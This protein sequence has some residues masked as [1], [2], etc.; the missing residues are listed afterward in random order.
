MENSNPIYNKKK[1]AGKQWAGLIFLILGIVLLIR[2][3][4]GF[5][6]DWITS[7]PMVLI[8][9]G[10]FTGSRHNY[11]NPGSIILICLGV[12][13]LL[14]RII[15]GIDL[16]DFVFPCIIIGLGLYLILGKT[17]FNKHFVNRGRMRN[18]VVWDKRVNVPKEEPV[19]VDG[20]TTEEEPSKDSGDSS[21]SSASSSEQQYQAG[22][23]DGPEDYLDTV[24]IFGGIKKNIVS[25]NF[26][27]GDI[28]TIMGGAEINLTQADIHGTIII[29]ITQVFGGTKLILPPQWKVSSDLA[30]LF[31]GI[32][33]KRPIVQAI[34]LADDKVVILRG[35][36]V[37]GGIDIRS[38]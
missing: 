34:H 28:V 30:A 10:V 15:P 33:D 12:L 35:T 27:G 24:S 11:R 17:K 1:A 23:A 14:G 31:G 18:D 19:I 21:F 2:S 29:D 7:W 6:P 22:I 8:L 4:G 5:I 26:K 36:S 3:F 13:F 37:F 20:V 9:I 32:E 25:K 16:Q 38:Y